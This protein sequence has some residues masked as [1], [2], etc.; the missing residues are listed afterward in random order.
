ME[1][2]EDDKVVSMIVNYFSARV[3]IANDYGEKSRLRQSPFVKSIQKMPN[4]LLIKNFLFF[5]SIN[6]LLLSFYLLFK[7]LLSF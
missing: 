2:N 3:N 4:F 5:L 6:R 7:M 1:E